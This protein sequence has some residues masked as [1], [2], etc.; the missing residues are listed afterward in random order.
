M[1]GS[2]P[3]PWA[4]AT[5]LGFREAWRGKQCFLP[6]HA[7]ILYCFPLRTAVFLAAL[8]S[9][10]LSTVAMFPS[11]RHGI[12]LDRR[13]FVG[14]YCAESRVIINALESSAL[15]WGCLGLVG[16]LYLRTECLKA[17]F[18]YQVVRFLA[19]LVVFCLDVPLL[20]NCELWHNDL[21]AAVRRFGEND[22]MH[23]LS[24]SG[25][26]SEELPLFLW[27]S[28]TALLLF[29][30]FVLASKKL[31][32]GLE[33]KPRFEL[34]RIQT[35]AVSGGLQGLSATRPVRYSRSLPEAERATGLIRPPIGSTRILHS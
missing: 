29:S 14:G 4:V 26:C 24:A 17:F 12:E 2:A 30:Q 19:W 6:Q 25:H 7:M 11:F 27:L 15:I 31:I 13:T 18:Y 3:Q 16:S 20:W 32:D 9:V 28:P 22:A 33:T 35:D 21:A 34:P 10:L 8:S 5:R 1:M 23:A